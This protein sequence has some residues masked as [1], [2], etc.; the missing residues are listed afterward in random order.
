MHISD[1]CKI[2]LKYKTFLL[3]KKTVGGVN[4]TVGLAYCNI[5]QV[6]IC[7]VKHKNDYIAAIQQAHS[8]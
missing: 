7:N 3:K 5:M 4:R 8:E 1:I 2:D 6:P